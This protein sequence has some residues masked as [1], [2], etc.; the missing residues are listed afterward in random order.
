MIYNSKTFFIKLNK[1]ADNYQPQQQY[2]QPDGYPQQQ[3]QYPPQQ[4]QQY[5]PQDGYQQAE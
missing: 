4:Q 1:M 5:P 3:Q 2:P